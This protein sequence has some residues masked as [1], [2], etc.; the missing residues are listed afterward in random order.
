MI[1]NF[2]VRCAAVQLYLLLHV[3]SLFQKMRIDD[4]AELVELGEAQAAGAGPLQ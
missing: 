3:V 1:V 2:D 4:L